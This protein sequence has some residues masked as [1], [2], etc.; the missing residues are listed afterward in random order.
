[1]LRVRIRGLLLI[2]GL[3]LIPQ[4]LCAQEVPQVIFTGPLSHPRF[5]DGGFFT[6]FEFLYWGTN[7]PLRSQSIAFRGFQV[8]DN[9]LG[10][11]PGT[12]VGSKEEALNVNQLTGPSTYQPG[13]DLFIGWRFQGGVVV[14]LGWKHLVQARFSASAGLLSP[15][16][17]TGFALEN[18]FL[19]APV[20]NFPAQYAGNAQNFPQGFVGTTFGIWNAASLME[21][22]YTQRFDTYEI[23]ARVPILDTYD[24]RTYGIFGPRIAWIWDNFRWRTV[25]ADQTGNAG[26]DTTAIYN[27]MVSNRMYGVHFGVGHDWWLGSTPVGGFAFTCE[28]EGAMYINLVKTNAKYAL[29]D[30]SISSGRS[31]RLNTLVPGA[32]GRFGFWWYPWEAISFQ[33]GYDVMTFFNTIASHRPVDFNLGTVDPEYLHQPMRWFYGLRAGINFVW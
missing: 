21:M 33:F 29:A 4:T 9:G 15:S 12:F 23:K 14:E 25:D 20:V 5:E 11:P 10:V 26:P 27:N 6:G 18:T 1:M 32:E 24:Y 16:F 19:F 7:Q 3:F 13:W 28:V 8:I 22:T 31:R 2:A 30:R 17:N